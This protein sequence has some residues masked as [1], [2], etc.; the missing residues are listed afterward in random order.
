MTPTITMQRH[1]LDIPTVAPVIVDLPALPVEL[2]VKHADHSAWVPRIT[3][4]ENV[5]VILWR[6]TAPWA[7]GQFTSEVIAPLVI[8][9]LRERFHFHESAVT[10]GNT[11]YLDY[12]EFDYNQPSVWAYMEQ[13]LVQRQKLGVLTPLWLNQICPAVMAPGV[14]VDNTVWEIKNDTVTFTRTD[15]AVLSLP[16]EMSRTAARPLLDY[17]V[18]TATVHPRNVPLRLTDNSASYKLLQTYR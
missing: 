11:T 7:G 1:I 6:S 9:I 5:D 16:M 10:I 2:L 12:M 15:G 14:H 18:Q 3:K 13:A 8:E 4:L 17:F